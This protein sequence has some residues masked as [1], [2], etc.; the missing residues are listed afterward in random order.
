VFL[1]T[2]TLNAPGTTTFGNATGGSILFLTNGAV[3]NN[4]SGATW[5]IVNGNNVFTTGI[6]FNGGAAAGVQQR[7]DVADD[8]RGIPTPSRWRSTIPAV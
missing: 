6:R 1:D 7:R 5:N 2:R 8:R 3:V 4:L